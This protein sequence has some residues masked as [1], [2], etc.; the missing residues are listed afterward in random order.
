M[1]EKDITDIKREFND[2][3]NEYRRIV[4]EMHDT[5]QKLHAVWNNESGEAFYNEISGFIASLEKEY[6]KLKDV[7]EAHDIDESK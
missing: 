3:V 7:A 6:E 2:C 4:D 5:S 1:K